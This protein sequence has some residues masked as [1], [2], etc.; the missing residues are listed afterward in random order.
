MWD[1]FIFSDYFYANFLLLFFIHNYLNIVTI[2][3]TWVIAVEGAFF[4][5]FSK[6]GGGV[7][8]CI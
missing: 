1:Y 6:L 2:K 8:K 5:I 3:K 7:K 4:L